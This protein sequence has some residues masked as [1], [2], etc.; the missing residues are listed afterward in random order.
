MTPSQAFEIVKAEACKHPISEEL[1]RAL[2]DL[3][4][5]IDHGIERAS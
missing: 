4:L 2:V 1:M 3:G 5:Y